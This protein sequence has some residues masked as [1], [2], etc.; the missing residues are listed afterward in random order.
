VVG[1]SG[2]YRDSQSGYL[3]FT[4]P[5]VERAGAAYASQ[6]W[7]RGPWKLTAG[8]RLD[9]RTVAPAGRDTNK[10]GVI[11]ER[12]FSGWSG[13][14][15]AEWRGPQWLTLTTNIMRTFLAP[16]V[17]H[18][19]AEGPH[20]AA[21]SYDVGNADLD[22]EVG[23]GLNLT[24]RV[25]GEETHATVSG[26]R[27]SFANYLYAANTG[28]LEVGP[29]AEGLLARYQFRGDP[30]ALVGCDV[31][32]VVGLVPDLELAGT[33]SYVRGDLRRTH[34][35]LPLMPPA[36]GRLSLRWNHGSLS[37]NVLLTGAASQRRIGEFEAP[38]A[39]WCSAGCGLGW[40][41]STSRQQV[42][43]LLSAENVLDADYR[44]HLSRI[45]AIMPEP[46]RNVRLLVQMVF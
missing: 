4:P 32:M 34:E 28:Q 22:P 25:G 37:A 45:K 2:E 44:D 1:V 33:G 13:G 36:K 40:S 16:S 5:T 26:Y 19:F 23:V 30:A 8:L 6:S 38:T 42:N 41:H 12:N 20:L 3:T 43:V 11:R 7:N 35:P 29:G 39:G 17:E 24:A 15:Q 9:A 31:E 18:L 27:N 14:V 10:A 21:Y 46:G